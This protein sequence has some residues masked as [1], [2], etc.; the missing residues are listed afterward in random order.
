M[1]RALQIALAVMSLI[2]FYYGI[3]HTITGAALYLPADQVTAS[4]DSQFRFQSAYYMSLALIV[5]W[6]IPQIERQTFL[7]RIITATVFAGGLARLYSYYTIG[8]PTASM[9]GGMVLELTIP[10]VVIWQAM[11]RTD[12]PGVPATGSPSG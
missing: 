7:F 12:K 9:V 2:P 6:L 3:R 11:I 1:R 4:I 10:L 8:V 5:W